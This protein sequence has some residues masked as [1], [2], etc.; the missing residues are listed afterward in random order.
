MICIII[1][2]LKYLF[3]FYYAGYICAVLNEKKIKN[4]K[5]F[6]ITYHEKG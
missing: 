1:K 6:N 5:L 3:I 4:H 2:G